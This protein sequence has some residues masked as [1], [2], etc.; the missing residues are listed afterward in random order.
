MITNKKLVSNFTRLQ[1]IIRTHDRTPAELWM[2][3]DF[4]LNTLLNQNA[5]MSS[6]TKMVNKQN[7][8]IQREDFLLRDT[9]HS[10]LQLQAH[11]I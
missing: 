1:F 8:L 6:V 9:E 10:L 3:M 5:H 11:K 2:C 4:C 7:S